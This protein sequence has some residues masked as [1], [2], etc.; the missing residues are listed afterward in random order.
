MTDQKPDRRVKRTRRNLQQALHDLM[1]RKRYDA[2]TVQDIIEEADVGR[3]TFYAHYQDKEDL[4]VSELFRIM[5]DLNRAIA[6]SD[7]EGERLLPTKGLF[8]HIAENPHVFGSMLHDR[9]M[10][11]FFDQGQQYWADRIE[12]RLLGVLPPGHDP[13]LP[14]RMAAAITAGTLVTML[15]WWLEN[16]M[17]YSAD[18]MAQFADQLILPGIWKTLGIDEIEV[19]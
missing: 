19:A 14:V 10:E 7:P 13:E 16:K 4:A 18:Q 15:R 12:E 9:G 5:D 8:D 11:F 6:D 1:T 2:I 17:P 3:S